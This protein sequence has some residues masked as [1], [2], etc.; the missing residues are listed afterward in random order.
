V[1]KTSIKPRAPLGEIG[2][3]GLI[4]I[5]RVV[6]EFGIPVV[7][8]TAGQR[9]L[10]AGIRPGDYEA[11][12][13]A[14]GGGEAHCPHYV[15]ACPGRAGCSH[16]LADG[17][18]LGLE[19]EALLAEMVLPAKVKAGVSSCP[20]S[21][22]ESLVRDLGL[23]G[24]SSGWSLYF[25]GNAGMKPRV[26]DLLAGK[27]SAAESLGLARRVLEFYAREGKAKE[28]TAR[29][30]ERIGLDAVREAVLQGKTK[31]SERSVRQAALVLA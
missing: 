7:R 28:R 15:Q 27:L 30:V 25:G 6:E 26:G 3:E 1:E 16:A 19:L 13:A 20:R 14:L 4:R 9:L 10:L 22:A 23:V 21:C 24:R 2:P 8:A 18:D 29:F 31:D 17:P 11:V 5:A 12:R